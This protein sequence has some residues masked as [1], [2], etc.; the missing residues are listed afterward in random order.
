MV[1]LLKRSA[2][3][4]GLLAGLAT[5]GA[6]GTVLLTYLFTGRLP[7]IKEEDEKF[8]MQLFTPDEIVVLM[9]QQTGDAGAGHS[10]ADRPSTSIGE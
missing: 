4:L 2:Y 9:R 1:S 5:I 6:A 7:M 10:P 3:Y 8:K